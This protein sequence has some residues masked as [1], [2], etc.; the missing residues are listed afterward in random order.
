MHTQNVLSKA[1]NE[2]RLLGGHR[3]RWRMILKSVF[4]KKKCMAI[5]GRKFLDQ[6][7]SRQILKDSVKLGNLLGMMTSVFVTRYNFRL[8][9]RCKYWPSVYV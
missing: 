7:N 5:T 9:L 8:G 2:E 6:P 3:N 1:E 4:E